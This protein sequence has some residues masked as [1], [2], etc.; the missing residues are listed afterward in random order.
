MA[1]L[2]GDSLTKKQAAFVEA[3]ANGLKPWQ[4]AKFAGYN[5]PS[6]EGYR[7]LKVEKIVKAIHTRRQARI[8]GDL[9]QTALRTLDELMQDKSTAA[10]TRF[11]ASKLV[12]EYAGHKS[13]NDGQ[14]GLE[15]DLDE[16]DAN[17]LTHAISA[18]MQALS[19]L[20]QQHH[21]VDGEIRRVSN[22]GELQVLDSEQETP[23]SDESFL[24]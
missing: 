24:D 10:A 1:Q 8:Q 11:N 9:A 20:A 12:L 15:K 18:G 17:E 4:A 16:M 7:L 19:E 3:A 5:H 21:I 22:A 6:D 14:T 23:D 2:A 13:A